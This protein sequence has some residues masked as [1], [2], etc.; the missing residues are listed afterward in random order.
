M[1]S[2]KHSLENIDFSIAFDL[3]L[4]CNKTMDIRHIMSV[5][6]NV[7]V[8]V[9]NTGDGTV[10][11]PH[12]DRPASDRMTKL[13]QAGFSTADSAENTESGIWM[14]SVVAIKRS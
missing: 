8:L 14:D 13:D 7:N 1:L 5:S 9:N 12:F 4:R 6:Q 10:L 2:L 11:F 3:T